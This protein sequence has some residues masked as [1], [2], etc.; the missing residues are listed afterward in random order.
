MGPD[1]MILVLYQ[2]KSQINNHVPPWP[3][4]H[5][6]ALKGGSEVEKSRVMWLYENLEN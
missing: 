5:A 1:A 6:A 2:E 4:D 3:E